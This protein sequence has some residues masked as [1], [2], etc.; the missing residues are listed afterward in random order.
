MLFRDLNARFGDPLD[1]LAV[2][3]KDLDAE[4]FFQLDDGL[5]HSRLGSVQ[6]LGGLG[7]VEVAGA[8]L[9]GQ[10]GTGADS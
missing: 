8:P 7:Q 2:A 3:G 5:G 1:P 10:I 9:P 4:L 6:R